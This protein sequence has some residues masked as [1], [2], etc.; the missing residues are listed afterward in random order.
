M[1]PA[2]RADCVSYATQGRTLLRKVALDLHSGEVL[3]V[4]GPNGAGKSTLCGVLAGDI[5]P[6]EGA[7]EV[8]ADGPLRATKTTTLARLRSMLIQNTHM[9]FPF[10]R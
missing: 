4:V 6:T 10:Y 9:R 7:V 1:S 8:C 3:A 2:L 5:A